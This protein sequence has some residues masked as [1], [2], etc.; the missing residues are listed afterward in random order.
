MSDPPSPK[1]QVLQRTS[2]H[3]VVL[4]HQTLTVCKSFHG[5]SR[6]ENRMAAE[7]E[8]DH[9][10]RF[11][12]S[13][14]GHPLL[15]CPRPL[16]LVLEPASYVRMER[17]EGI[18]MVDYLQEIEVSEDDRRHYATSV[19]Q[20]LSVY[21]G[22]FGE[23][24]WDL[25]FR[26]MFVHPERRALVLLDFD[27]PEPVQV[28]RELLGGL[29]PMDVSLGNLVGSTVFNGCRPN[30]LRFQRLRRQSVALAAETVAS[31]VKAAG[32]GSGLAVTLRDLRASA[33]VCFGLNAEAG[34]STRR[35][36]YRTVG[37]TIAAMTC[38]HLPSEL[39]PVVGIPSLAPVT[40]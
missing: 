15:G 24:Y 23:P 3:T 29:N 21:V 12:Q 26:N 35:M 20:A 22:T 1:A 25:H 33:S 6:A 38:T 11:G 34:S 10:L 7:R 8:H 39:R 14:A 5:G 17:A 28:R 32:D 19:A 2:R 16:E 31:C 27:V 13:L 40:T 36:W 4:E 37:R 18:P 9:L 30:Q